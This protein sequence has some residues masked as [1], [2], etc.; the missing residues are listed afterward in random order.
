M[1]GMGLAYDLRCM[2]AVTLKV[3]RKSAGRIRFARSVEDQIASGD[4]RRRRWRISHGVAL[5]SLLFFAVSA[6]GLSVPPSIAFYIHGGA[7]FTNPDDACRAE[8]VW[9][10]FGPTGTASYEGYRTTQYPNW[11]DCL[12]KTHDGDVFGFVGI[13]GSLM[14][15]PGFSQKDGLCRTAGPDPDKNKGGA[16]TSFGNPVNASNGNKYQ[17]ETDFA[18]PTVRLTWSRTY[19]STGALPGNRFFSAQAPS[20]SGWTLFSGT[21]NLGAWEATEGAPFAAATLD[22]GWVHTYSRQINLDR[23]A[24]GALATALRPDGKRYTFDVSGTATTT[25]SDVPERL[26]ALRDAFGAIAGWRYFSRDNEIEIY[27]ASGRLTALLGADGYSREVN[28]DAGLHIAKVTDTFSR[29]LQLRYDSAARLS[30]VSDPAGHLYT[31]GYDGTGALVSVTY[32]DASARRY[33]YNEAGL[34]PTSGFDGL[35]SG[36]QDAN[37]DRYASYSYDAN[38]RAIHTEHAA[39]TDVTSVDVARDQYGNATSANV[40]DGAGELR[41]Y[42]YDNSFGVARTTKISQP[43]GA[44]CLASSSSLVYDVNGNIASRTDFSNRKVCYANDLTRN[45][46]VARIEGYL[47]ADACPSNVATATPAVGTAQR[48]VSTQWHPYWRLEVRRAEP[49]LVTTSV[50]NGQPDPT[51]GG[52][53]ASC[54]PADAKVID[55]PIAVLCKRVEQ[56]T[57]DDT[58][59]TAFDAAIDGAAR[60]W[61]YTYNQY[62]QVLTANGPR[63]DAPGGKDD[64]TTY[65][66]YADTVFDAAGVG[67]TLGDLATET[68]ALGHVI[69]YAKYDKNGRLLEKVDAD[70][71]T[72]TQ[73][74]HVRGW[75][76]SVTR[77]AGGLSQTTR[78]DYDKVGQLKKVTEP[79]T[80]WVAYTYDAAHRL[81]DVADSR[82]NTVHYTL[83]AMGNRTAED[84]KDTGGALRRAITRSYDALNRLQAVTGTAQ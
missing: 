23:Y 52:A 10:N 28:Y 21:P 19:N 8:F 32:P 22:A 47:G 80:S 2:R 45:L 12:A 24:G 57:T 69:N 42:S 61:S 70:G 41:T 9:T 55:Q 66:Y 1:F 4:V 79:D 54:A 43:S 17:V 6:W 67:H 15:R 7:V 30:S 64:A 34:T 40:T 16:C 14:C 11:Y 29:E 50:Y 59:T 74:W 33:F 62:G 53:V 37:G 56:P 60:V 25:D 65:T 49:K 20:P 35:L 58:G 82:G 72:T 77:S 51:N 39:G 84:W 36:I 78:Y 38:G 83:D 44:G 3:G 18:L 63:T 31:Y 73:T 26:V 75:L 5:A 81:T 27:N 71:V 46:E 68:N 76:T 48:K 13:H